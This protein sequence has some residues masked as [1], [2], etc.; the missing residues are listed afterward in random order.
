MIFQDLAHENN[1]CVIA[2]THSHDVAE[3]SDVMI[4]LENGNLVTEDKIFTP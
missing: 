4:R 1:K 2:V 3:K